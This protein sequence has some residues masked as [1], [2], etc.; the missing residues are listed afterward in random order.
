MLGRIK[1]S[2]WKF[3]AS[4][5]GQRFED[6]YRERQQSRGGRFSV[7]KFVN[8]GFGILVVLVGLLFLA[9]PGPGWLTLFLGFGI[10]A[11]EFR[12]IARFM[13]WA[14]LKARTLLRWLLKLWRNSAAARALMSLLA[15]AA[16]AAAAYATYQ[17]FYGG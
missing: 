16:M 6:R 1:E 7:W 15:L 9:T 3:A 11:S 13:D 17:L 8:V 10:L 4:E 2:Y 14:E 12:Y 5:P